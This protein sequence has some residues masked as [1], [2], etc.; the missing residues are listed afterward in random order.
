MLFDRPGSALCKTAEQRQRIA[1]ARALYNDPQLIVFDEATSALDNESESEVARAIQN[2]TGSK[3]LLIVSH[4]LSTIRQCDRIFYLE[5]GEVSDIG[6]FDELYNRYA[7]F[8]EL[9]ELG[10]LHVPC[11]GQAAQ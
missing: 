1:I 2:L 11:D 6:S 5:N 4:R 10:N 7:P 8:R 9:V 3:T